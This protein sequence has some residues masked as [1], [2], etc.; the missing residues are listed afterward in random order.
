M[1]QRKKLEFFFFLQNFLFYVVNA[2]F[3]H[4]AKLYGNFKIYASPGKIML[5][6]LQ[7]S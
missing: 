5:K 6:F 3:V 2:R 7:L 1:G 4:K